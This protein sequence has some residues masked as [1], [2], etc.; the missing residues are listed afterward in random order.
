MTGEAAPVVTWVVGA[1]GLLGGAL[2]R[3]LSAVGGEL[4][5]AVG[6]PWEDPVAA[7]TDLRAGAARLLKRARRTGGR[8]QVAWCAGAGV[9]GTTDAALEDEVEALSA[10]LDALTE[11]L[12]A[13]GSA[14]GRA[15]ATS[16]SVFVASSVGGVYAGS[17][18]SP[19]TE[20]DQERPT[21]AYGRAKLAG[22]QRAAAFAATTGV[23]VVIGRLTNLYGPGQNLS[24]PQG[25]ISHLCH[26]QLTRQPISVYV[27]LDT[28]RDYLFVD[29]CADMIRLALDGAHRATDGEALVKIFGS[30]Q[31]VTIGTLIG[32][33]RRVFKRPL[34]VVLGTS[35]TARYQASDLRIRSI[36][37]PELDHRAMTSLPA[38]IAAT[39]DDLFRTVQ[40]AG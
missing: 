28:I 11:Q 1:G 37:W 10:V 18:S 38:G 17:L 31:P 40:L 25:L 34:R 19:F 33:F 2:G 32:E 3:C 15:A 26:A 12:P 8:W 23:P 7:R 36:V 21:S 4:L 16:G 9:T 35:S 29:D 24:K 5:D 27:P 14:S 20:A 6:T 13:P 39:A 30:H 22:E